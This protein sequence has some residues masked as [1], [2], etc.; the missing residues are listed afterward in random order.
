MWAARIHVGDNAACVPGREVRAGRA[1]VTWDADRR[2][3]V[4]PVPVG[5]VTFAKCRH[6]GGSRPVVVLPSTVHEFS[7]WAMRCDDCGLVYPMPDDYGEESH[8]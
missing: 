1:P 8:E 4:K 3:L 2:W 7:G 6:G 5:H